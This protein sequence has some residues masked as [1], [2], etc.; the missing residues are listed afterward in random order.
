MAKK[1][2]TKAKKSKRVKKAAKPARRKAKARG[3][4]TKSAP[5]KVVKKK[6]AKKKAASKRSSS[7][8]RK[9]SPATIETKL[10]KIDKDLVN[11]LKQRADLT[12]RQLEARQESR[13]D[14][15]DPVAEYELYQRLDAEDSGA[16]STAAV[17]AV[18]RELVS[19][20]RARIKTVR[21]VYLGPPFS[22]THLA[23]IER[24][25]HG[26][27]L[28]PVNTIASVFEEVNRGHADHG[29]VPIENSTD[30]RIVDTLD[31][32][33]RLPLRICGEVQMS[34]HHNLMSRSPRSEIVE[35]Y[36]KPQALSQCRD[37]LARNMPRANLHEVT[38]TSTAAQ[39]AR[40]KPGAAAIASRQAAVQYDLQIVAERI[41]DNIHNVTRFAIIGDE[42]TRPTGHD[43]TALLLQIPHSPGSLSEALT[44]FKRG[45]IN[46]TWIESFPLRGPEMGYLF[47][48]D[49]EGHQKEPRI[50]KALE[51]L[52]KKA[53]RMEVLGSYPRSEPAE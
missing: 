9:T 45:K 4:S 40:D 38:S 29:I 19:A 42:P 48:L 11:L 13:Q 5:K 34:V 41:E 50:K 23:A 52:E 27:D 20:A 36:S 44:A 1:R 16:V 7:S 35:V 51:D 12:V 10:K 43:R 25:G 24:F 15:F 53:V 8:P 21:V 30:G 2:A 46:L 22:F 18:F 17:H 39:L 33:T 31:M 47:F 28:I 37:W 6:V 32:F 26:A 14:L 3:R 49:F